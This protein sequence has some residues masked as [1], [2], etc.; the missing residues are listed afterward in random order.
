MYLTVACDGIVLRISIPKRLWLKEPTYQGS[1]ED[2][3]EDEA[4]TEAVTVVVFEVEAGATA[5]IGP[6]VGKW[7]SVDVDASTNW[8]LSGRGRGY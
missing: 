5:L 3:E 7:M 2:E 6:V 8:M 1:T 4:V